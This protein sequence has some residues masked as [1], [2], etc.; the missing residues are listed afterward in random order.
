MRSA[1]VERASGGLVIRRVASGLQVLLIDDAYGKVAFP[2]G[3]LEAGESWEDA[4]IREV[5][6]ET[7]IVA[8]IIAPLGRVEY[9][10]QRDG[11]PARKQVRL[12][13]MEAQSPEQQPQAQ[14][15]EVAGAYYVEWQNG[16]QRQADNGY[17][18]WNWVFDKA[19]L[20]LDWQAGNH[21]AQWRLLPTRVSATEWRNR[22]IALAPVVK[23]LVDGCRQELAAVAPE[24]STGASA[25]DITLPRLIADGTGALRSA[26]E[27]TL[28][29]PE[30]SQVDVVQLCRTAVAHELH[31]VCVNPQ[32]VELAAEAVRGSN[33]VVCAVVGFPL[34]AA[35]P[36]GLAAETEAVIAAGAR[37]VD[38]VIPVGSMREDDV[39]TVHRHVQGVCDAA[40]RHPGVLVKVILEAHYLTYEQLAK[41]A[42]VSLAAGADFLKTSTGFA[43]SGARLADVALMAVVAGDGARV[44]AAGGIRTRADALQF[45]ACGADRIGTSSGAAMIGQ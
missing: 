12:F 5:L 11:R 39:W 44:K 3:H 17:E 19:Q 20:V 30:A 41:A 45:L 16:C 6:E 9:P 34:G 18:N 29:K 21:E 40:H 14:A 15:E 4:A 42:L 33:V 38:M 25:G 2:K 10:I 24:L 36:V 31:A 43:A 28:L 13:L 1:A 32:H 22:W 35:D 23:K 7:G 27:H 37:E 26:I 8:Q